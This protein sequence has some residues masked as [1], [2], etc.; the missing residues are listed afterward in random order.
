MNAPQQRRKTFG[1]CLGTQQKQPER[2]LPV[3]VSVELHNIFPQLNHHS[4]LTGTGTGTGTGT[5]TY[6]P[7]YAS[8]TPA[9]AGAVSNEKTPQ[10]SKRWFHF[11]PE[12]STKLLHAVRL[13]I[14][15]L[16]SDSSS[17]PRVLYTEMASRR[18]LSPVWPHLNDSVNCNDFTALE[19]ESMRA[20]FL[21]VKDSAISTTATGTVSVGSSNGNSSNDPNN[22]CF[23]E[24]NLHPSKLC[25]IGQ[26]L[27]L[28]LPINCTVVRFSDH[29]LRIHPADFQLLQDSQPQRFSIMSGPESSTPIRPGSAAIAAAAITPGS[30]F[31]LNASLDGSKLLDRRLGVFDDDTFAAL[32]AP[33]PS[34]VNATPSS[35][36]QNVV[37]E[38][39]QI[40]KDLSL[41]DLLDNHLDPIVLTALDQTLVH[42]H[43]NGTNGNRNEGSVSHSDTINNLASRMDALHDAEPTTNGF[44]NGKLLGRDTHETDND[45]DMDNHELHLLTLENQALEQLILDEE[46][47]FTKERNNLRKETEDLLTLVNQVSLKRQQCLAIEEAARIEQS[48]VLI[49][50]FV[51]EAQR[52]RLIR[53]LEAIYPIAVEPN[54]RF[55]IRGLELPR[56]IFS[57]S[58]VP[59]EI[60]S[61][62]LGFLCHAIHL[63]G[64]YLGVHLKYRLHCQSSRS[65]IQDGRDAIF[66]LFLGRSVDREHV[67]YGVHLLDRNVECICRGRGIQLSTEVHMLAKTLRIYEHVIEGY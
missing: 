15:V 66:P 32:D 43:Q 27:P 33:S 51:L 18:T 8:T 42:C 64:K 41:T 59:D 25:R 56:F 58:N 6:R 28:S 65:A 40:F 57:G 24:T 29:S 13:E 52:I 62:S 14:S 30:T 34:L 54:Q 53:E 3:P 55:F 21:I 63:M 22:I 12:Y 50:R 44:N 47:C 60:V 61:A 48:K 4:M 31:S 7:T 20:R 46:L 37:S 49:A 39:L 67:E 23:L 11:H 10:K 16:P 19:Y 17:S 26:T 1:D 35:P 36:I 38:A 2:K 45:D 5:S 9:G